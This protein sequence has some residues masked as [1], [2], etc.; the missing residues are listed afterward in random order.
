MHQSQFAP[1]EWIYRSGESANDMYFIAEGVVEELGEI[2]K[3]CLL[4]SYLMVHSS[5]KNLHLVRKLD[6]K[7][8]IELFMLEILLEKFLSFSE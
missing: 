5:S 3:V 8:L 4:R 7:R 6:W 1:E 2:D